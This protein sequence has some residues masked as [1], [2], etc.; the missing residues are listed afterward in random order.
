M[1][2]RLAVALSALTVVATSATAAAGEDELHNQRDDAAR[3]VQRAEQEVGES[4]QSLRAA[5]RR[6]QGALSRLR[7]ARAELAEMDRRVVAAVERDTA[8]RAD[9]RDAELRLDDARAALQGA[10]EG[11]VNQ[12]Q[13]VVDTVVGLYQGDDP[14]L[15]AFSSLLTSASTEDLVRRQAAAEAL[16]IKQTRAY[17]AFR[18]T[19]VLAEV[20][21]SQVEEF[22][23]EVAARQEA[24]AASLQDLQEARRQ[25]RSA[26][27]AVQTSVRERRQSR[28]R[29]QRIRVRDLA[30]LRDAERKEERIRERIKEAARRQAAQATQD[31][32]TT[33]A[34][35]LLP[36]VA[37]TVSSPYGYRVHPIFKYWGLHDGIDYAAGCGQALS[38]GAD[39]VVT[40]KYYSSVYG[41]RLFV[42]VGT[43][44]G[45]GITLV[46]NHA[47]GYS[48]A[49][50]DRVDR[51]QVIGSVG[52][53]GWSTGCHLHFTVLANGTPTD[54]ENWY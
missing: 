50:G 21:E 9:L 26:A 4:S 49:V 15:L 41:Y 43:A 5:N 54:P 7:D 46:Y 42:N 14:G 53:T 10:V 39:G 44:A 45:K 19:R 29:A 40:S 35:F 32:R 3:R 8:L 17:N 6:L 52:D 37:G 13:L 33:A 18:A 24:A 11:V 34:G 22:A 2:R 1:T 25:A 23:L 36:P 47:A 30:I 38:A 28:A 12:K 48:V 31:R 20:G 51:G 27:R 16:L